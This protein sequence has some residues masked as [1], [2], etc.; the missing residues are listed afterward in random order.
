MVL[1]MAET[2]GSRLTVLMAQAKVKSVAMAK[3][4]KVSKAAVAGWRNDTTSIRPENQDAIVAYLAKHGVRTTRGYLMFGEPAAVAQPAVAEVGNT[5][6]DIDR[7]VKLYLRNKKD[8]ADDDALSS[9]YDTLSFIQKSRL[10][11]VL[12]DDEYILDVATR[13]VVNERLGITTPASATMAARR[14]RRV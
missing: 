14:K 10:R 2:V 3:A 12:G 4:L 8:G 1:E 6:E 5:D 9:I 11:R 7:L 13:V